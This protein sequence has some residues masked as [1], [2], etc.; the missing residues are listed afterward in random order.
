MTI[1]LYK[2]RERGDAARA[3]L[4]SP[5]WIEAWTAYRLRILELLEDAKSNDTDTVMHLKRLL[6]SGSDARAHL[7]RIMKEGQISAKNIEVDEHRE[8]LARR[9][10]N[11]WKG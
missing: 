11:A 5:I 1:N 6:K 3:I 8:S 2:E 4:E 10:A 9:V 7:E